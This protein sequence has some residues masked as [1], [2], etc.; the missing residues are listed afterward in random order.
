M[1]TALRTYRETAELFCNIDGRRSDDV[2][3]VYLQVKGL[4]DR[5]LLHPSHKRGARGANQLPFEEVCRARLL[6][7]LLEVGL[8][9]EDLMRASDRLDDGGAWTSPEGRVFHFNLASALAADTPWVL[10]VTM[11]RN[12]HEGGKLRFSVKLVPQWLSLLPINR[13]TNGYPGGDPMHPESTVASLG[14]T[15]L[16]HIK[17]PAS[18]LFDDLKAA[19]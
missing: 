1:P 17:V 13:G 4:A 16:A 2:Q 11:G 10:T 14:F 9:G 18:K 15:H 19:L 12:H 8:E 7:T 5:G 3:A 6:L